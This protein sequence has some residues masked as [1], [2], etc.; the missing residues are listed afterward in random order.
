MAIR[1]GLVGEKVTINALE[2]DAW[3]VI[4]LKKTIRGRVWYTV[5]ISDPGKSE[6]DKGDKLDCRAPWLER[7][8]ND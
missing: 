8:P 2:G 6:F 5:H 4:R 3:G 7:R 1:N